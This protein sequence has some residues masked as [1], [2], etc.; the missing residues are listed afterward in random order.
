MRSFIPVTIKEKFDT[1]SVLE[2]IWVY[3]IHIVS[4]FASCLGIMFGCRDDNVFI[5]YYVYIVATLIGAGGAT[6]LITR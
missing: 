6:M 1:I 2:C 4:G 3:L 5:T